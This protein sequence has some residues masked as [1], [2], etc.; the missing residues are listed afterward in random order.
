MRRSGP[1]SIAATKSTA[2]GVLADTPVAQLGYVDGALT[3]TT[4]IMNVGGNKS[5]AVLNM[6]TER[7]KF[8]ATLLASLKEFGMCPVI[9]AN[10]ERHGVD[11]N[12]YSWSKETRIRV[13]AAM[14]ATKFPSAWFND[15]T[16]IRAL[17]KV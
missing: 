13:R 10:I 7:S 6:I 4:D 15:H 3:F 11:F 14:F 5:R 2:T 12:S 17:V 8:K 1:W 16:N 9:V